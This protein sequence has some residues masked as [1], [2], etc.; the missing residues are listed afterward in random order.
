MAVF[1]LTTA[2][3]L[4]AGSLSAEYVLAAT[5]VL[6]CVLHMLALEKPHAELPV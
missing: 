6:L 2:A 4:A 1:L 3:L 5:L